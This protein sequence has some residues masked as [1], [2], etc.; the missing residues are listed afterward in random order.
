MKRKLMLLLTCLF[1]GIGLVTAQT[2]KATGVVISEEDG[3]P[4]VGASVL[5]KGTTVGVI[6]DLNGKF[7]LS[8]IPSSA[9]TLQ[10]SYIG[11]Q[12]A[13]VAIAPNIKVILKTDSKTLDEVMIVAYGTAKKSS[14]TGSASTIQA[15]KIVSGS[16]ES[17][18]KALSGKMAGVRTA[19]A[20]GD[21]G[22]M[23]EINIRGVG[24]ISGS[25]TPLYVIDGVVTK[26]DDDMNYYGKTQSVLSTLN[27]DDIESMTVLKDAA[28]ASLYGSR[29]AN[30]VVIITTKKGK[31][32][33]STVTYSGE[34]GWNKM[35]VNQFKMMKSSDLIDYTREGLANYYMVYEGI[36]TKEEALQEVTDAD[37]AGF[38]H[39]PD[40][41]IDTNWKNEIY[42]TAITQNH[43]VSINGGTQNT[44]FYAG[45]G[46]NKSEGIVLGSDF[47]RISGRLNVNHKVNKWLEVSLKEMVTATTQNGFRDQGDQGQ[48][49]G[50]S[51]P[52][53]VL[54][55][56]DPTSP[57]KNTD[58]SYNE[59]AAWGQASNPHLM[60][61]GKDSKY[62]LEW[63]QS[64]MFRS[65]TNADVNIRFCDKL[66][67]KTIFGYDYI[68]NKHFE[69]W[70]RNSV[71]GASV[72]GMGSRYSF[73]SRVATSSS[74]L[75]YSDTFKD[76]HNLDLMAG[77][78]VENRD[79]LQIVTVAKN[80]SS[81]YPELSNGQPD[82]ASSATFGAGM[83]SYFASGN[84]NYDNKYYLSASFRRDG[85][86]RLSE[87]NRW[88]SF[89]SVSGAWR[90]SKE[91]FMED[92]PLFTDFKIK[93]SFGTNGNLPGS[94]YG[95]MD[96]FTGSGYGNNPA[97]YW[98]SISNDKLSWEKSKNFNVGFEWNMYDRVNLSI[99][100]YNKKTT[101]L[102]FKVPTS[103][104][105]GFE[106]RWENLGSLKNDGVELEVNSKNIMNKNF[107]WTT[108]FNMTYQRS[109]VDKL[110]ESKDIEYGDGEMYL[111]REG[112]SMYTFYLPEWKGVNA[113]TGL[114]EFWL[115]PN[116][117][118]KGVTNY[119]SEAGK[120]VVGK[121]LPDVLGGLTNTFTYKDFD[122]S[123]LITYQFGGDMFDY[124]GY[125]SHHDGVRLGS[126][127]LD[128]DVA[129]NFWKNPGDKV[130]NP[131]PIY[132][133]PYR[134]DRFSSR[135]IKSTD[136]IRLR[137]L[138]FGYTLPVWKNY[139]KTCR[140]YFRAN[141]LA[142]LWSKTKNI[143]PDVA[144]NGYRQADTPQLRSCVFGINIQF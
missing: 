42:R 16:R 129:G 99:E 136:N 28:A 47:E 103:L 55:A 67:F 30:G 3:Q 68:D 21:P 14:F 91:S 98:S 54:F 117:H 112:E 134:W 1:I 92:M 101:D 84:Y 128:A 142:M 114:G 24:S 69:Y 26:S 6:T 31:E 5:A 74:T 20:T 45:V 18:D 96:L 32:G 76:M 111:H 46:Y 100:Y 124:P 78:E 27:P 81:H 144:M 11:M 19:S 66:N 79:L 72:A 143:D 37:M 70:D 120:G 71:N 36:P 105:T 127:N 17:F 64:K 50:T 95:Y 104:V 75:R 126:T 133:N 56:M 80:Y 122:L 109:L 12:T 51:S 29:A 13:E 77:F 8:G 22:S 106:N 63:I 132:G 87:D 39:N 34:V 135:T 49:L 123:F 130:D 57:V 138:T 9:K 7:T 137:E 2:Q 89:W 44:Q 62:S 115:D 113:E 82:Q 125:F 85:S 41:S 61:G 116:D 43:Q 40:G 141:N 93:A 65:L 140:I 131:M 102:L 86:S 90:L 118:S 15:D 119:Y 33:K 59:N 60:L 73:E 52:L 48:G 53:G 10:I 121:A 58:G 110:P 83:M 38:L 4:V 35:A 97:I 108:N 25:K 94:Y 23:G 139:L 107:T 88:A